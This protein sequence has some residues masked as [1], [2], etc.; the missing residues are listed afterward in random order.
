MYR[1]SSYGILC[2]RTT[3][4]ISGRLPAA[5][6]SECLVSSELLGFA[7]ELQYNVVACRLGDCG[8]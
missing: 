3:M 6:V 4:E 1:Y 7:F 2:M 5:H 8:Q